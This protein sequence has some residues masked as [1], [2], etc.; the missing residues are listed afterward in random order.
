MSDT[1]YV[2][3]VAVDAEGNPWGVQ[4]HGFGAAKV[5]RAGGAP[6]SPEA[7][8]RESAAAI[9]ESFNLSAVVLEIPLDG[10]R[11]EPLDAAVRRAREAYQHCQSESE[12]LDVL[13]AETA[14]R[15]EITRQIRA[16]THDPA[17]QGAL[18]DAYRRAA[19]SAGIEETYRRTDGGAR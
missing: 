18:R 14:L 6:D 12:R 15:R 16:A 5:Y 8:E 10:S 3:L 13:R 19:A 2:T 11:I 1:S 7:I 17:T 4:P 9:A